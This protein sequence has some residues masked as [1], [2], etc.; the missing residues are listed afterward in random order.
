MHL[1]FHSCSLRQEI[2][3]DEYLDRSV[4]LSLGAEMGACKGKGII[5][6]KVIRKEENRGLMET[7]F[8]QLQ[9]ELDLRG[10]KALIGRMI[11]YS[12]AHI[13]P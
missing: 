5:H 7:V 11:G 10:K 13:K 1:K 9:G 4:D 8:Q 3:L 2:Q 12:S 6:L